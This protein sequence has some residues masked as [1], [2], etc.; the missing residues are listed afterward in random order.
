MI[1]GANGGYFLAMTLLGAT[2]HTTE[3]VC[4]LLAFVVYIGCFQF[5]F[6]LGRPKTSE[7]DGKGE[8][9]STP[10]AFF[11][12]R[13]RAAPSKKVGINPNYV[14]GCCLENRQRLST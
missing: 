14:A 10:S 4:F 6:R 12:A 7:P 9:L 1:L 13:R 8:G 2:Y 11:I 3:I 5:M